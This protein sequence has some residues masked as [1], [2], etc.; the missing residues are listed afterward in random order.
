MK[1]KKTDD[2]FNEIKQQPSIED[3]FKNNQDELIFDSLYDIIEYYLI[4]KH[5]GKS[6]VI[7]RSDLTKTYGYEIMRGEKKNPSRDILIRLCIGMELNIEETNRV[8]KM[9][10]HSPL[11]P[12]NKRDAII[13]YG[14]THRLGIVRLNILL[15]D[16]NCEPLAANDKKKF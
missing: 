14:I 6:E 10:P 2:L 11:Y 9:V 12:R 4:T 15:K 7:E 3:Y 1:K 13:T 8:L 16:Y 5:L